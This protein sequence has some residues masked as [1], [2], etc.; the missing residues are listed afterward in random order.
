[1]LKYLTAT[2]LTGI[3]TLGFS[4]ETFETFQ[5][6]SPNPL[7]QSLAWGDAYLLEHDFEQAL[8]VFED[9]LTFLK[10]TDIHSAEMQFLIRLGLAIAYDNL[11]LRAQCEQALGSLFIILAEFDDEDDEDEEFE[12]TDSL[13]PED[14]DSVEFMR[15]LADSARSPDIKKFLHKLLV[16]E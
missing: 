5:K 16:S 8:Q 1:M 11:G 4:D 6:D 14:K 15:R 12:P 3:T 9:A 10:N 7:Y 13:S 2:I